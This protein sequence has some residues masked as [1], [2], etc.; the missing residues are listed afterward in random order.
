MCWRCECVCPNCTPSD[1]PHLFKDG[2]FQ[3]DWYCPLRH[4]PRNGEA[5]TPRKRKT[6][7]PPNANTK[8]CVGCLTEATNK[9]GC[10]DEATDKGKDSRSM[11]NQYENNAICPGSW[12]TGDRNDLPVSQAR[13]SS[14]GLPSTP[15]S[16]PLGDRIRAPSRQRTPPSRTIGGQKQLREAVEK[17][18]K[19]SERPKIPE[20]HGA[21]SEHLVI[22]RVVLTLDSPFRGPFG[23]ARRRLAR[24]RQRQD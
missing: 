12:L 8:P 24:Q 15:T 22:W 16:G 10:L 17:K 19:Q 20:D 14:Y 13:S 18:D 4:I 23:W 5:N 7:N 9:R 3:N 11:L 21:Q 2:K 6:R 1:S